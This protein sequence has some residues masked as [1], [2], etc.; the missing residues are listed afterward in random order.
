[1]AAEGI[2]WTDYNDAQAGR[3]VRRILESVLD[4]AGPG[5][6]RPATDL[7]CG[8]GVEARVLA[9]AGWRVSAVDS[10]PEMPSRLA[11]LTATGQVR[12]VTGDL[13]EVGLP[14]TALLHSSFTL[15]FV[16]PPDFPH[17]WERI[18]CS[19]LPGAWLA[20]HLFGPRDDWS[21]GSGLSIHTRAAVDQL[22]AGLVDVR[23]EE[24]ESDAPSFGGAVKHWHV[25]HVLA[26][27]PG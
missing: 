23:I 21:G 2:T 25:W 5:D 3:S 27:Q 14:S 17:L 12:A 16:P 20:V 1:M 19:L 22:V 4:L 15:P 13:R 18:R 9:A 7:G 10:D 8:S 11:D 26:R 6:G 24:E